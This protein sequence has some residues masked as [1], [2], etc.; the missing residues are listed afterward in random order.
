[1]L[2]RPSDNERVAWQALWRD[3]DELSKRTANKD[4]AKK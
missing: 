4:A 3:V 2:D 1:V